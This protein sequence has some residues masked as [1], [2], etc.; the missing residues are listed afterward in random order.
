M[1]KTIEKIEAYKAKEIEKAIYKA[2]QGY[3]EAK[4]FHQDSGYERYYKKMVKCEKELHELEDY[5]RKDETVVK[6]LSTEQYREYNEMKHDMKNLINKFFYMFADFNLPE[7]AEIQGIQR[8]LE[9][10]K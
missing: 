6:D 4:D 10:Y 1:N 5:L 3:E 8:I 7:T 2:K 9:K